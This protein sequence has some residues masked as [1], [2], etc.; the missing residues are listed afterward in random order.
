MNENEV[1]IEVFKKFLKYKKEY[2]LSQYFFKN[3]SKKA[4]TYQDDV[5]AD[6]TSFLLNKHKK[7]KKYIYELKNN[8]ENDKDELFINF[9]NKYTNGVFNTF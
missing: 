4:Y 7:C 1:D 6:W 8:I 3:Y 5:I 9:T 2:I